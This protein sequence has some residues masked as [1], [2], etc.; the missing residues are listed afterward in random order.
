MRPADALPPAEAAADIE[1]A[2]TFAVL[3]DSQAMIAYAPDVYVGV[4]RWVAARAAELD[5]R[6]VLHVGDVVDRGAADLDQLAAARDA[7]A[8]L[9]AAGIP[10]L[11][12]PGNH[13]YDDLLERTRGLTGFNEFVGTATLTRQPEYAGRFPGGGAE[14]S[15]LL[16]DGPVGG[17]LALGLEFGPRPEVVA[18]ADRVLAEHRDRR[19]LV[20]THGYLD[21]DAERTSQRSRWHPRSY[22]GSVDGLDGAELWDR[23]LSRHPNVAMVFC[24]HQIT[25]AASYRVDAGADGVPVL[26]SFQNWQCAPNDLLG[27]I[28]IVDWWPGRVRLRVVNTATGAPVSAPGYDVDLTLDAR[29]IGT[30]FPA[31]PDPLIPTDWPTVR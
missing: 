28:R 18:W 27:C 2:F 8:T 12:V 7:H 22:P 21:P 15:L 23:L 29:A 24:G 11:V 10:L 6:L 5:L 19:A 31:A 30:R 13:D 16:L 26:Q 25:G 1:D 17:V 14:N 9:F 3:P 20:V 4:T